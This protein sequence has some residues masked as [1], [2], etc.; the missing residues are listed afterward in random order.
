M[1]LTST[2]EELFDHAV[3]SLPHWFKN[4]ARN[5]EDLAAAAKSIGAAFEQGEHWAEQAFI[6]TAVGPVGDEPDWLAQHARDRNMDRQDGETD[7]ALRARIRT[8]ADAVT[9]GLLLSEAQRIVDED[10]VV[11]DA[12]MVEL[13]RDGAYS[14]VR[15]ADAGTGGTFTDESADFGANAVGFEPDDPF[16]C[17]PFRTVAEDVNH[18]LVISG[19]AGANNDGTHVITALSGAKAIYVDSSHTFGAD[20]TCSWTVKR[21][22]TEGNEITGFRAAYF[23]RGYRMMGVLPMIIIILPYGC[24]ATTQAK[25][26]DMLREKKAAGV[27]ALVERRLS[28]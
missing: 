21:Y 2:E 22:D 28:P 1:A 5:M 10:G 8:I 25:V 11:G 12:A 7:A 9:R 13:P 15:V 26:E 20:A 27:R 6:Q 18:K 23:S 19:A 14:R 3:K 24:D 16:A 4:S 17:P